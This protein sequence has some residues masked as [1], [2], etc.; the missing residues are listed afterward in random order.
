[1][2]RCAEAAVSQL[3]DA[4][5]KAESTDPVA[6][7][8]EILERLALCIARSISSSIQK[9]SPLALRGERPC[10]ARMVTEMS[11]LEVFAMGDA[12]FVATGSASA[13]ISGLFQ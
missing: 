10:T 13:E 11:R 5:A 8:A 1:M 7:K 9:R 3:A 12:T 6:V 4:V 2:E